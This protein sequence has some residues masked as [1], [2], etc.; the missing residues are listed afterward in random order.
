MRAKG[1]RSR[2]VRTGATV[3]AACRACSQEARGLCFFAAG[4]DDLAGG[5]APSLDYST[6]QIELE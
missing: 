3:A 4:L 5:H 1:Q 6:K 2:V